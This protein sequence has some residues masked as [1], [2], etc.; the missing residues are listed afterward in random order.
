MLG[1][2]IQERRDRER[3][4]LPILMDIP[5]LGDLVSRTDENANRT[6]LIALLTPHVIS[7]PAAAR[8]LSDRLRR[9]FG[10]LAIFDAENDTFR[11]PKK[12]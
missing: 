7:D 6:E 3:S 11:R 4:G 5:L 12:K 2:L 9:K 1:G 10:A 8:D